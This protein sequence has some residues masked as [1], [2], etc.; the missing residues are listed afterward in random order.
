MPVALSMAPGSALE[1]VPAAPEPIRP[2]SQSFASDGISLDSALKC[3]RVTSDT[4]HLNRFLLRPYL[5]EKDQCELSH[6]TFRQVGTSPGRRDGTR[7]T[8]LQVFAITDET[9]FEGAEPRVDQQTAN[10]AR[11]EV[12]SMFNDKQSERLLSLYFRFVYP[13]YPILSRSWFYSSGNSVAERIRSLPLSL[14]S[15]LYAT[16]LP[17]I[18]HDDYLN[19]SLAGSAT[20]R[21]KLYRISWMAIN[22]ELHSPRLAT[23]QA[24][25]LLLQRGPRNQYLGRTP[26]QSCLNALAVSLARTLGLAHDCSPWTSLPLWER[27]VRIRLWWTVYTMDQWISLDSG[28]TCCIHSSEY[29]VPMLNAHRPHSP[30]DALQTPDHC[31]HFFHLVHLSRILADIHETYFTVR[32]AATTC[33]DLFLSLELARP[34]RSRLTE[35]KQAFISDC[36]WEQKPS[37]EPNSDASLHLAFIVATMTLFRALL[38]PIEIH[39][40][41]LSGSLGYHGRGAYGAVYTGC[42]NCAREA[43][44]FLDKIV[45]ISG[46]WNG[47]WH[48]WSQNNFAIAST[49]LI[50]MSLCSQ[51]LV[52]GSASEIAANGR[53]QNGESSVEHSANEIEK[54]SSSMLGV[55]ANDI[56]DLINR[57]RRAI[58]V[59]G[60][61]GG[62]RSSLMSLA[63]VRIDGFMGASNA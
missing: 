23:L 45:S 61:S 19:A 3:A 51:A 60:G 18:L 32:A 8:T 56:V 21:N 55:M 12:V 41:Q 33:Q 57:W 5:Q 11:R 62:W 20:S 29:D 28:I 39:E 31:A 17:F 35:W 40:S 14:L 42:L 63:L 10:N 25:L 43:V 27:R 59:G 47:F 1:H 37:A 2:A 58:R 16:S 44:D 52:G 26:F 22:E 48:S 4:G 49:F 34:L 24:C 46:P 6:T 50:Q 38:R 7:H 30:P 15:S 54:A 53:S 36:A 9:L 13:A